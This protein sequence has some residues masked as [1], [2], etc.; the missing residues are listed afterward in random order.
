MGAKAVTEAKAEAG[1]RAVLAA[2]VALAAAVIT[3]PTATQAKA[4]EVARQAIQIAAMTL[5]KD[6][7]AGTWA[8]TALEQPGKPAVT[9]IATSM[10]ASVIPLVVANTTSTPTVAAVDPADLVVLAAAEVLVEPAVTVAVDAATTN[11]ATTVPVDLAVAAATVGLA[12]LTAPAAPTV[13]PTLALVVLVVAEVLEALEAK[14]AP[15]EPAATAAT[16]V[17][18]ETMELMA[19]PAAVV[20]PA[21]MET[22]VALA[23]TATALMEAAAQA[24]HPVAAAQEVVPV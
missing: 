3:P 21:L 11:H 7:M 18:T 23:L 17:K 5:V 24:V 20:T 4:G 9:S 12:V 15:V 2:Q 13:V 1:A 6:D 10:T 19:M 8:G 16:G 22:L 14:V